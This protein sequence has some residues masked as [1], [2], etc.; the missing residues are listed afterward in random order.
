MKVVILIIAHSRLVTG[1]TVIDCIVTAA[2]AV[3]QQLT[4]KK[5]TVDGQNV[6]RSTVVTPA[7]GLPC[8]LACSIDSRV[9]GPSTLLSMLVV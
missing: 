8:F 9:E 1:I 4:V 7:P 6:L 2:T 5:G 3:S